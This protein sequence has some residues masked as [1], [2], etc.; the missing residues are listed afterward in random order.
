[1]D[2]I[3][4]RQEQADA[5]NT[6][7]L[8]AAV[9]EVKLLVEQMDKEQQNQDRRLEELERKAAARR[10][11]GPVCEKILNDNNTGELLKPVPT[12]PSSEA[13]EVLE[14]RKPGSPCTVSGMDQERLQRV[15]QEVTQEVPKRSN[16]AWFVKGDT[17]INRKGRGLRRV[18]TLAERVENWDGLRA[19]P[20]CGREPTPKSG[21][22]MR[23]TVSEKELRDRLAGVTFDC[24][25]LLTL[26]VDAGIVAVELDPVR[27]AVFTYHSEEFKLVRAEESTPELHRHV[28]GMLRPR[29]W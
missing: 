23:L 22:L 21:R 28:Q 5:G 25:Y 7:N 9:A 17:R 4:I 24:P 14:A 2:I 15:I 19:C 3:D 1:M 10:Q 29:S 6:A 8:P 13:P 11:A 18:P 16:S 12:S 20:V 27:G 26:P